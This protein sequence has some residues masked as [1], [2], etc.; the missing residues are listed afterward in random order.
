MCPRQRICKV[1]GR[2]M[3]HLFP[4]SCIEAFLVLTHYIK[5]IPNEKL[6]Y[7]H[8]GRLDVCL[9][10]QGNVRNEFSGFGRRTS[11]RIVC[12]WT[13][14]HPPLFRSDLDDRDMREIAAVD[15][16]VPFRHGRA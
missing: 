1:A 2:T 6:D 4:N 11:L 12:R 9:L 14:R 8:A 13:E 3:I 10:R 7:G 15:R 5:S 16:S